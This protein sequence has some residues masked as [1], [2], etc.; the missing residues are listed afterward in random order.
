MRIAVSG[1]HFIGKSTFIKDFV[2]T[3]SHYKCE[4]EAYHKLGHPKIIEIWG[5]RVTRI[6]KMESY[7]KL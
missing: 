1:T 7:L 6:K 4:G 5:D 3:Y 2:K